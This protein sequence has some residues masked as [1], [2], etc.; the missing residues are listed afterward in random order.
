MGAGRQ[1]ACAEDRLSSA[2][3]APTSNA[4]R[5]P[6][7]LVLRDVSRVQSVSKNLRLS[8][9]CWRSIIKREVL[10]CC[11]KLSLRLPPPPS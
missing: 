9:G 7:E 10:Q 2:F 8:M 5:P 1:S 3:L 4:G 6:R 11:A